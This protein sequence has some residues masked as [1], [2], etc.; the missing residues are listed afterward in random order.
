MTMCSISQFCWAIGSISDSAKCNG[1][2][3]KIGLLDVAIQSTIVNRITP[4]DIELS[5]LASLTICK[6]HKYWFTDNHPVLKQTKCS[7]LDCNN[8]ANYSKSVRVSLALSRHV[9]QMIGHY[10]PIGSGICRKHINQFKSDMFVESS[11][12]T[13]DIDLPILPETL[14]QDSIED[15]CIRFQQDT[16]HQNV[17]EETHQSPRE[18]YMQHPDI[19]N[20]I[21]LDES[22]LRPA[23]IFHQ[24]F[25]KVS[26]EVPESVSVQSRVS[27]PN[28]EE[29]DTQPQLYEVH[30]SQ[31]IS[32][33][34]KTGSQVSN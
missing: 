7:I 9:F 30:S 22:H 32:S 33:Q 3:E 14:T 18:I 2:S 29:C 13:T 4:H 25:F 19:P 21:I 24:D 28:E 27:V 10:T 23:Q 11:S 31:D 1:G 15:S 17:L 34:E 8:A 12:S 26:L 16:L 20:Q 6:F 5:C